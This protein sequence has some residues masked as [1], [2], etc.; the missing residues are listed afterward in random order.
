VSNNALGAADNQFFRRLPELLWRARRD[1]RLEDFRLAAIAT[2][3]AIGAAN[4]N[5]RPRCARR[6]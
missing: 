6:R 5:R 1:Q 3:F 2:E 4:G